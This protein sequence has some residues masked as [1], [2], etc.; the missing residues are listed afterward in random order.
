MGRHLDD[1]ARYTCEDGYRLDG[2]PV[3]T[4]QPT[5]LWGAA[6]CCRSK[7]NLARN[8]YLFSRPA[9]QGDCEGQFI[10]R[11]TGPAQ[12][13]QMKFMFPF[14]ALLAS[15]MW[16]RVPN[17]KALGWFYKCTDSSLSQL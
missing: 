13:L 11:Y 14:L 4:C 8:M 17:V 12:T 16:F 6:P 1:E 10:T 3:T 9:P 15:Y 5:G 7:S 2:N